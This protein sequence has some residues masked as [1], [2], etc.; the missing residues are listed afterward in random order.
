MFI[1]I[2]IG[3]SSQTWI[4]RLKRSIL[5]LSIFL[6]GISPSLAAPERLFEGVFQTDDQLEYFSID[7]ESQGDIFAKTLSYNGGLTSNGQSI[8]SGGFAPILTL[9]NSAG[10]I[11]QSG[12]SADCISQSG[13]FCWDSS[14]A[15][16]DASSGRYLLVL[17]QD[18][19][20]PLGQLLDG[21][22]M[23]GQPNFTGSYIGSATA[24]FIQI[25][26]TQRSSH[27][28][29]DLKTDG[30]VSVVPEPSSALMLVIGLLLMAYIRRI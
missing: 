18:G 20:L 24:M 19:N 26:G 16:M 9:F 30:S 28:A 11:V 2:P 7:L 22:S 6:I 12:V 1:S 5:F 17:S 14:L 25:D 3:S 4:A 8:A 29:L 23:S 15:L 10:L 21:F 13:G 27:W